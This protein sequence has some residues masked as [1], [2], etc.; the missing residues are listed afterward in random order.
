M[1]ADATATLTHAIRKEKGGK[2]GKE[3]RDSLTGEDLGRGGA[4]A[5]V[6][7]RG[8]DVGHEAPGRGGHVRHRDRAIRTVGGGGLEGDRAHQRHVKGGGHEAILLVPEPVAGDDGE[9]R[10]EPSHSRAQVL[11]LRIA[12]HD[13]QES[14]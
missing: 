12:V 14:C 5:D 1:G 4:V 7:A 6:N 11:A 3:R 8:R 10:L 2:R 13:A 9:L